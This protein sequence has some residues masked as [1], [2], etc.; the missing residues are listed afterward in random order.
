M[1]HI[2]QLQARDLAMLASSWTLEE[3]DVST[4]GE[5]ASLRRSHE[6]DYRL[7]AG[8][9][10]RHLL[11]AAHCVV[12][13]SPPSIFQKWVACPYRDVRD[14]SISKWRGR[15]IEYISHVGIRGA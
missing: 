4:R 8:A 1:Q 14:R 7:M 13:T 2:A 11:P 10:P 15:R 6:A 3:M 9:L 5:I 12:P